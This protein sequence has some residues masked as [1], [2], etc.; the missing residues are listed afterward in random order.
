MSQV[1][2]NVVSEARRNL[3]KYKQSDRPHTLCFTIFEV[4][5]N[6]GIICPNSPS[7]ISEG[8]SFEGSLPY[9][10]ICRY[11]F[12]NGRGKYRGGGEVFSKCSEQQ[13]RKD[14]WYL[15]VANCPNSL[16]ANPEACSN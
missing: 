1:R 2:E 12:G 7:Q 6:P 13:I 5:Y 15:Y 3:L 14:N 10:F 11:L 9:Q 8:L 16:S 4:K